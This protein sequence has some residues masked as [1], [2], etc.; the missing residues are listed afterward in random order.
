M[1]VEVMARSCESFQNKYEYNS[2]SD[3]NYLTKHRVW[4][5]FDVINTTSLEKMITGNECEELTLKHL[6][7]LIINPLESESEDKTEMKVK[8]DFCL[9]TLIEI[10]LL[11]G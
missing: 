5:G 1:L 7:E 2:G 6:E 9:E 3:C 10:F 11:A 8:P 4:D